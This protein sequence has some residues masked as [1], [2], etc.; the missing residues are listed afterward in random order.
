MALRRCRLP[1]LTFVIEFRE[2]DCYNENRATEN[3][4]LVKICVVP[5]CTIDDIVEIIP[6]KEITA[7]D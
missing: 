1:F 4:V 7:N 5:D 2:N 6:D 3:T